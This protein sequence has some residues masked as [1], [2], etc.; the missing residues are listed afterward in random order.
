[1]FYVLNGRPFGFTRQERQQ[2]ESNPC[3]RNG[4]FHCSCVKPPPQQYIYANLHSRSSPSPRQRPI[5]NLSSST[6]HRQPLIVNLSPPLDHHGNLFVTVLCSLL[7]Y[8]QLMQETAKL[9]S[10]MQMEIKDIKT[11]IEEIKK[12]IK[13]VKTSLTGLD[14][15]G[16]NPPIATHSYPWLF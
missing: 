14:S 16:K 13:N 10:T 5:I 2:P 8:S 15:A 6:S 11:E 12:E 1:M 7:V 3:A 9:A 4:N